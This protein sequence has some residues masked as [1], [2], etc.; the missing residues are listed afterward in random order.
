MQQQESD[1]IRSLLMLNTSQIARKVNADR[2]IL[3]QLDTY[4]PET[5]T[6]ETRK[7]W[8]ARLSSNPLD[9]VVLRV[10]EKEMLPKW[11]S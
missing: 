1:H 4:N 11:L 5:M 3:G 10:H 7:R 9:N 8:N 2:R 6:N